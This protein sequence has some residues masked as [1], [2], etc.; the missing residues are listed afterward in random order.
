MIR[1]SET[2][3]QHQRDTLNF[4]LSPLEKLGF[5]GIHQAVA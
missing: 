1:I 3:S 5:A 2:L 4:D